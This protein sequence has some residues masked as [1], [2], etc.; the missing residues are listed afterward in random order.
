MVRAVSTPIKLLRALGP[1]WVAYR[2]GYA[3]QQKIGLLRLRMPARPW[4]AQP[5]SAWLQPGIP[6]EPAAYS[7]WRKSQ[8]P[9]FFFTGVERLSAALRNLPSTAVREADAILAG[10]WRYFGQQAVQV[11]F[12]PDWHVNPLSGERAPAARH[13]SHIGDFDHGDIKLIWEASRFSVAY[14]LVR[15]YAASGDERYPAAFWTLVKDWAERNPPQRGPNWMSGQETAFRLMAWCFGLFGFADS[16]STTPERVAALAAMLGVHAQRIAG[17]IAY[18]RSQKNNHAISEAVGLWTVGLLFPEFRQAERWRAMGKEILETEARR[19]IYED[20]SYVQHSTHYHRLMLDDYLWALRLGEVS[21]QQFSDEVCARVDKAREFLAALTDPDT[22]RVP[23]YGANDGALVLPLNHCDYADFRPVLQTCHYL[24]HREHLYPPGPWDEDLLWLFG[25]EALERR[26]RAGAPRSM[27]PA[28]RVSVPRRGGGYHILRGRRSW[29]LIRCARYLD[30]PGQA[31]QLHLDLWWRGMNIACDAGTYL[32]NGAPPWDNGLAGTAV[33]NTVLVDGRDQMTRAGRFLWL[34]WAQGSAR[35]QARSDQGGLELWEGEHDGYRRLGVTHRRAV[36]RASDATWLVVDDLAGRGA[37]TARL[38]WLLP[39]WPH[40]FEA[41]PGRMLLHAPAG[42]FTVQ[43]WCSQA[44]AMSLVRGG[45]LLTLQP[46]CASWQ[47]REVEVRGWCSRTYADKEP[48]L[49]VAWEAQA[50]LPLRFITVF[51]AAP[52]SVK[53]VANREV[54]VQTGSATLAV[55]LSPPGASPIVEQAD[56]S[57]AGHTEQLLPTGQ[58]PA[59]DLPAG[60]HTLLIHQNFVSPAEAGGTRHYELA[61]Q[62]QG[63]GHRFTIV[64]SNL[65]F[66]TGQRVGERRGLITEQDL[67]GVRVLRAYTYSALHRSYVW[68]V[69]SYLSFAVTSLLATARA[70]RVD[71][72]MGTTPPIFQAVSAWVVA[73]VRRRPFVL[74]VR[75][76]WPEFAIDIGVLRNPVLI[77]LSRRLERFLYARADHLVVNSPAYRDYLMGKGIPTEKIT[78]IPNGTDPEMFDPAAE[79][80]EVRAGFALD[81][82]FVVTYAGALGLAND[83]ETVLRAAHRLRDEPDIHFLLVGDGKERSSLETQA[84]SLRLSNV[85]FAGAQPKSRMPAF[86]AASDACLAIL[87][88]IPMFRTTYPNKVFDYMAA[89]RPTILA[90]DGV[91]REVM[92]AAGGGT[93][94]HPGDDQALADAVRMLSQDRR[95]AR[96]MGAAARAYVVE[97]FDRREQAEQFARLVRRLAKTVPVSQP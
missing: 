39:D 15:A 82:K 48:A 75:D 56:L 59:S 22:G 45:K 68:R 62:L 40:K 41:E 70:G 54:A 71:L 3:L 96:A 14:T 72:V 79:G 18:A 33:H 83:L 95:R 92:E 49:S 53:S 44:A 9:R 19:Q 85:T 26:S 35:P 38:H 57:Q 69:V 5:L 10:V 76:L 4:S 6:C 21:G 90:I 7:R 42:D 73:L 80:Q 84:R 77:A 91:I 93:F 27:P 29:A 43:V 66:L 58:L 1:G 36:L 65:S 52:S 88:D 16:P 61:R 50:P 60:S 24:R 2:L 63:R 25:P 17:N 89:G 32:Y 55:H 46:A 74:E 30:R 81:R 97:H 34:D 86:L 94:V 23:N 78:L 37:H 12:P 67:D 28:V 20:G 64:A 87:K 47:E 51:H 31:D 13:W 11:G 8:A